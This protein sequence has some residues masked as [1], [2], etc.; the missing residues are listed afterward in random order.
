MFKI[1]GYDRV[2]VMK[3]L[4]DETCYVVAEHR[5]NKTT[6]SSN[7][8]GPVKGDLL[9]S[10]GLASPTSIRPPLGRCVSLISSN[11]SITQS[12]LHHQAAL[13][14]DLLHQQDN[15]ATD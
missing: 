7:L 15:R 13:T 8:N 14:I 5:F 12:G 3:F 2:L 9:G 1:F 6:Q 10:H 4:E 11:P